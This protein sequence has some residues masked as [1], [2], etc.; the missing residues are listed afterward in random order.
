VPRI[1]SIKPE[2]LQHRKVGRLTDR[3][4]R[5]WIGMLTQA[6]DDGRLVADPGQLRLLVFG[7]FPEVT[8]GEVE[9][10]IRSL[11]QLGLIRLYTVA[12]VQYADLPSWH[13]HQRINRPTPSKLPS[14]E[15]ATNGH[16]GHSEG[17][18]SPHGG[19][20]GIGKEGKGAT[21]G[22]PGA[23][24]PILVLPFDGGLNRASGNG[25]APTTGESRSSSVASVSVSREVETPTPAGSSLAQPGPTNDNGAA[26][27]G[28]PRPPSPAP[29]ASPEALFELWN[30]RAPSECP[31]VKA[32]SEARRK[33]VARALRQF[34]DRAMW[35][36]A[37]TE[38]RRSKFLRGLAP[39]NGHPNWKATFDWLLGVGKDGT[40]NLVKL[41]EGNYARK[42][43]EA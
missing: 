25:R 37:L 22:E 35:E 14:H 41:V 21:T 1:R 11:A 30:D 42:R 6:D 39:S 20:E 23:S 9:A 17:P 29:W 19:S 5:L 3:E 16:G 38:L 2:S 33:K 27:P 26:P 28:P 32:Q 8:V 13:D 18:V 12:W 34:P 40:E 15:E 7:Y 31:R 10:A 43:E 24:D 36:C 4:F